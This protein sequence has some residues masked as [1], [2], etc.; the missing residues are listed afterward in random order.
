[1]W[2]WRYLSALLVCV[3]MVI[4]SEAIVLNKKACQD[5]A[6]SYSELKSCPSGMYLELVNGS[7][8]Q[9]FVICHCRSPV[10]ILP[11]DPQPPPVPSPKDLV[12]P[13]FRPDGD[14]KKDI[15]L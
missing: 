10:I 1:M 12:P 8:D 11:N 14:E 7:G 5:K 15:V 2:N 4:L 9:V 6:G 3:V 13:R